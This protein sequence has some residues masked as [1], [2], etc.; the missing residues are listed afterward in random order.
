MPRHRCELSASGGGGAPPTSPAQQHWRDP[1]AAPVRIAPAIALDRSQELVSTMSS[2]S[3]P[4]LTISHAAHEWR[5]L[6]VLLEYFEALPS[7]A[8]REIWLERLHALRPALFDSLLQLL[9]LRE[10]ADACGF[11]RTPPIA[12]GGLPRR[13]TRVDV[14]TRDRQHDV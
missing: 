12:S 4:S 14:L 3:R 11:M 6:F 8:A 9:Q 13:R 5:M 10:R 1:C 2:P 7:N